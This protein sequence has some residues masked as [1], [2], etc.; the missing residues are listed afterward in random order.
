MATQPPAWSKAH[1]HCVDCG[2]TDRPHLA[3][4]RCTQCYFP[5]YYQEHREERREW[6]RQHRATDPA[7]H[8]EPVLAWRKN[9]PERYKEQYRRH[10]REYYHRKKQ[11]AVAL[12]ADSKEAE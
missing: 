2:T 5:W 12:V 10:Q 3:R 1:P 11:A 8:R 9:N 7:K 4:G 6:V